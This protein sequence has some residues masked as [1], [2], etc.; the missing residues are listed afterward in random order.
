MTALSCKDPNLWASHTHC[1]SSSVQVTDINGWGKVGGA[2][3][4]R[5]PQSFQV[6]KY[7]LKSSFVNYNLL[8]RNHWPSVELNE[9]PI[10]TILILIGPQCECFLGISKLQ[11]SLNA[12]FPHCCL[13][14][15]FSLNPGYWLI[16]SV[17][18]TRL[19][20]FSNSLIPPFSHIFDS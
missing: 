9:L 19:P 6:S 7:S 1:S 8:N 20:N 2:V 3:K 12:N 13:F 11:V 4:K 18:H 14:S 15:D 16:K 17:I 5:C 10:K